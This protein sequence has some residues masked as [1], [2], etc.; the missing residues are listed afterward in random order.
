MSTPLTDRDIEVLR[1][2]P[3]STAS[4]GILPQRNKVASELVNRGYAQVV[5]KPRY[6]SEAYVKRTPK[7]DMEARRLMR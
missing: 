7:G 1:L 2:L 4:D 6:L 5:R 3:P